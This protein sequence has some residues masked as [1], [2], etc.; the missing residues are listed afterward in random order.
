M[1]NTRLQHLMELLRQ[2]PDDPF[3]H[4]AVALEWIKSDPETASRHFDRL[5]EDYPGYLPAYYQAAGL[6]AA[7]N[8]NRRAAEVYEAGIGLARQQG[9]FK[10][11]AE[12]Q[13]AYA[14]F[15]DRDK[16]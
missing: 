14:A 11:L 10:T 2:D 13:A 8:C 5:L 15:Q 4:Y 3:L 12:L 7:L 9:N 1:K 6:Y 16:D